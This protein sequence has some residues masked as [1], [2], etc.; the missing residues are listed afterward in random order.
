MTSD[1]IR[2]TYIQFFEQ[3]DHRRL[4][5][6]SLIPAEFDPSALFTIAGMHPAQALLPG[7]RDAAAPARDD[8]PEDVPHRP[9]SRSS[10]RPP[11]T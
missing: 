1:E 5:S 3:R 2:D 4:P 11:G 9:T 10:A 7:R 6:S 8:L